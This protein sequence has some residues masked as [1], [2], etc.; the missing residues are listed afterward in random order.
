VKPRRWA[1]HTVEDSFSIYKE[2]QFEEKTKMAMANPIMVGTFRT[3]SHQYRAADC[4]GAGTVT[5][6]NCGI[7]LGLAFRKSTYV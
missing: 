4:N 3:Y 2:V 1:A 6:T 5:A 7:K